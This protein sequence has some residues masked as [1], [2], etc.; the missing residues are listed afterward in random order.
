MKRALAAGTA[1]ATMLFALGF[2]L[3]TVRVL[4]VAPRFGDLVAALFEIPFMLA[5]AWFACRWIIQRWNIACALPERLAMAAWFLILLLVF[6]TLL[7]VTLFGRTF[8]AQHAAFASPEGMAGLAAQ[9]IAALF[10]LIA[11]RGG[12]R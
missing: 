6:E 4:W 9:C 3:G 11:N 1:Y 7:G 2:A 10:A 12:Q 8:D 5:A